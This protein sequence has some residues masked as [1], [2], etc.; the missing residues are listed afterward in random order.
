MGVYLGSDESL[1]LT[2][3]QD[4]VTEDNCC[5]AQLQH[6]ISEIM[7]YKGRVIAQGRLYPAA[8]RSPLSS[9]K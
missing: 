2:N 3:T 1:C 9:S 5:L 8:Y 6:K 7:T 4:R